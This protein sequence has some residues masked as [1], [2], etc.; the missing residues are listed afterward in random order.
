M[1]GGW[2]ER[3]A[4][5]VEGIRK[6]ESTMSSSNRITSILRRLGYEQ[7]RP[8]QGE[9]VSA[10]LE[11]RDVLAVLPTGAGKSLT[12]QL[13]SQ[14]LPGVTVVVSPLIALM[15]DQAE[16]LKDRGVDVALI[17]SAQSERE[18]EEELEEVEQEESK[19]LYVTPERFDNDEFM[20]TMEDVDVSLLV[21]D[22]AHSVSEWG[23]DFRPAYLA[24]GKVA[25]NLGRPPILALTATATPWVRREIIER[26][27]MQD[28]RVVVK[29]IYR[30]NLHLE[31]V[32]VENESEDRRVLEQLL[33][34]PDDLGNGRDEQ[35]LPPVE[36]SGIIYTATT[37]AAEETAEWLQEWG[38]PADYYHGQRKKAERKHAQEA[39]MSGQVRVIVATNAFGLGIDKP[40]VRF[41]IHR[42]TPGSVEAYYQE[43]GRAGRD[44]A[45]ARCILIYRAAD[46]GRAAF[47]SGGGRLSREDVIKAHKVLR[48]GQGVTLD[49][50]VSRS[51]LSQADAIRLATLLEKQGVL[52][53]QGDN[54]RLLFP[55][56]DPDQVSLDQEDHR[57]AY[58]RSRL[59]MM[60]GYAE[61]DEC[62]WEYLLNYFGEEFQAERCGRCDKDL[63]R[64]RASGAVDESEDLMN[65][66][67]SMGEDVVHETLGHG[68]VQRIGR[69]SVTVLFGKAGYKTLSV[70]HVVE[71]ELLRKVTT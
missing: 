20:T 29:G 60:R 70:D 48:Q 71:R 33:A 49:Q 1:V 53:A 66:P 43:A 27:G 9:V 56:F 28:P 21:V 64:E 37:K 44:G 69:D 62:R 13:T 61:L 2:Y 68:V 34:V 36:G 41:V 8:G 51:G 35:R 50:L 55:D 11:G 30:P 14:L 52:T 39:F 16:S 67:F 10:L 65:S 7:F 5:H 17:N 23:H 12:Y 19:L 18:A 45:P 54:L 24:L 40:D 63:A 58:E 59:D 32:R 3:T 4:S 25:E 6:V 42:H 57:Q 26:L 31:V 47:L 46:L 15:K 22:E 38:V